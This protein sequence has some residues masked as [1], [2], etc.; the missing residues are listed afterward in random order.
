M[1]VIKK[2]Y[3]A[4]KEKVEKLIILLKKIENGD[5]KANK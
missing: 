3:K 4:K 1:A 2:T 5:N